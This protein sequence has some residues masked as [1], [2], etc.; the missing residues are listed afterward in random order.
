MGRRE[1]PPRL[2]AW[3]FSAENLHPALV[4]VVG[5]AESPDGVPVDWEQLTFSDG[6]QWC[7]AGPTERDESSVVSTLAR[8]LGI[9][10]RLVTVA[11]D[12]AG[13]SR[14]RG[15]VVDDPIPASLVDVCWWSITSAGARDSIEQADDS[16]PEYWWPGDEYETLRHLVFDEIAR[17][18]SG[19]QLDVEN[20]E[21]ICGS[22]RVDPAMASLSPRVRRICEHIL[23]TGAYAI[24]ELHGQRLVKVGR[25][26]AQTMS[27]VADDELAAIVAATGLQPS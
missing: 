15:W 18:D 10:M 7:V 16:Q 11:L 27:A 24:V 2:V 26:G 8:A 1:N 20:S 22:V 6:T 5:L 19:E 12:V 9:P 4:R 17:D 14:A 25:S 13:V 3:A 21:R 23:S